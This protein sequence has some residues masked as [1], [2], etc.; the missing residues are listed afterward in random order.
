V[1][2][3]KLDAP[4]LP[5]DVE[6]SGSKTL[7][8]VGKIAKIA[9]TVAMLSSDRRLK[10]DIRKIGEAKNGLP[11]YKFKYKGD[12]KEQTHIGF[13]ADE[14]EKKHPEAVGS[15]GG[16][17]TVDYD[18]ATKK[19]ASGG[20]AGRRGYATPGAVTDTPEERAQREAE[21]QRAVNA[22]N[23]QSD[24]DKRVSGTEPKGSS[25]LDTLGK[26][27]DWYLSAPLAKYVG[28]GGD[29]S[30]TGGVA[31]TAASVAVPA[32]ETTQR[33][34]GL[35][36]KLAPIPTVDVKPDVRGTYQADIAPPAAAEPVDVTKNAE[37]KAQIAD[38]EK[39]QPGWFD[40][41]K[42][43]LIPLLKG[44]GTAA[45]SPSRFLG[46]AIAQG[47]GA[48]AAAVPAYEQQ[49]Q[50]II[51]SELGN[52]DSLLKLVNENSN[53]D[54]TKYI[55]VAGPSETGKGT[56][57]FR[58]Q[59]Y[60][61]VLKA[62]L[63]PGF[64]EGIG[65]APTNP[66][67][68]TPDDMNAVNS[69]F[70]NSTPDTENK[71]TASM[72]QANLGVNM[73][74]NLLENYNVMMKSLASTTGTVV[75]PGA[76]QDIRRNAANMYNSLLS[77][78]LPTDVANKYKI[79]NLDDAQILE[80]MA[81]ATAAMAGN[82]AGQNSL[83][84][85]KAFIE[86]NPNTNMQPG[87]MRKLIA[88]SMATEMASLQRNRYM[89]EFATAVENQYG[90]GNAYKFNWASAQTQASKKYNMETISK[91]IEALND[92][93]SDPTVKKE[94]NGLASASEKTKRQRLAE[95]DAKYAKYG[96]NVI[97]RYVLGGL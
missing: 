58:G 41:N 27:K 44:V 66:Y 71:T 92:F 43:W 75:E 57:T 4:E 23:G 21:L 74:R 10:H 54:K 16:Y 52:Q 32:A 91:D 33:T 2:I 1:E 65:K 22:E 36:P 56:I 53:P 12:P 45:A 19:Y 97:S 86:S 11:I 55:A 8:D 30:P 5:K 79:E 39:E 15:A 25:L 73:G 85:L 50:Q 69:A 46:S 9:A 62:N 95:L 84:G 3:Q 93:Y 7:G 96:K 87:A 14:V 60:H 51:S 81:L 18:K 35:A 76:L 34:A 72:E 78:F 80:K 88:K 31:P 42:S 49:K 20:V 61:F 37:V 6:S 83:G 24:Y 64:G 89:Q 94:L 40:R 29:E 17:K 28:L 59:P 82:E 47:V 26:A 70:L 77:Q 13:M 48:A 68:D 67:L 90:P 63:I 38:K